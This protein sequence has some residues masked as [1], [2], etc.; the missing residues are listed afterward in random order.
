MKPFIESFA[1]HQLL[2]PWV[3]KGGRTWSFVVRTEVHN[4]RQYLDQY[5]N[6]AYPDRAP[7]LYEP[8]P[9]QQFGLLVAAHRPDVS[10]QY[11]GRPPGWDTIGYWEI[12]W[13]YPV[14]RYRVTPDNLLV[15]RKVVW[16]QPFSFGDNASAV[17]SS[18]EI[19]GTDMTMA[20]VAAEENL[21]P[22]H[23]HLDVI[24]EGIK[25]F[26]PRSRSEQLAFIH[27]KTGRTTASKDPDELI[28]SL[29]REHPHLAEFV[30]LLRGS[31]EFAGR[32][33]ETRPEA[34]SVELDNLKQFRDCYN[35]EK[36]IYRAIVASRTLHSAID[37]LV[38]YDGADVELDF[39]WSDSVEEM[40][41]MLFVTEGRTKPGPP[42]DH[43]DGAKRGAHRADWDMCRLSM[44]VEFGFSY[45][46]NVI[47]EVIDTIHTYG[48]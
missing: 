6:G 38:F 4:T 41:K 30:T 12:Y 39:M 25:H 27:M 29:R 14:Y 45:T 18:R 40:L 44:P 43:R 9:G 20:T 7:F 19:W 46:S 28:Q 37:G 3:A 2:P 42:G 15:D 13:T 11:P 34:P 48:G 10:S 26:A 21:P 24:I 35:M 5:F 47:F 8:M 33:D 16:V 32:P 1:T 23:L 31:G 17:F 22:E 36:A